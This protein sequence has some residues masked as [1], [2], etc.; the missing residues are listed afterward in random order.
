[1]ALGLH[2]VLTVLSY[3]VAVLSDSALHQTKRACPSTWN[4]ATVRLILVFRF[5]DLLPRF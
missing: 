4:T 3:V 2:L 1:M 5:L